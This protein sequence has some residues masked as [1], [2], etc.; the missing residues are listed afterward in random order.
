MS[1][2]VANDSV[3]KTTD[4]RTLTLWFNEN[5]VCEMIFLNCFQKL[6]PFRRS[7]RSTIISPTRYIREWHW[8]ALSVLVCFACLLIFVAGYV[9][10]ICIVNV[11]RLPLTVLTGSTSK[12]AI[13]LA[14]GRLDIAFH[15]LWEVLS[16]LQ[17]PAVL[18]FEFNIIMALYSFLNPLYSV[19]AVFSK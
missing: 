13:I 17:L 1:K 4:G 19:R 6:D 16:R 14:Q 3:S 15:S 9:N 7:R 10:T 2:V 5:H 18:H 8:H 11:F 12:M